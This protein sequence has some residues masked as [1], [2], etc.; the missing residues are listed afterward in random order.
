MQIKQLLENML[1]LGGSDLHVT[2]GAS[3]MV[4]INGKLTFTD[5]DRLSSQD[6]KDMVTSI[7]Q[8]HQKE[9]LE[10]NMELSFSYSMPGLARFRVNII[11]QRGSMA[12]NFRVVATK[13]PSLDDLKLPAAVKDLCRHSRGLVLV[14]GP[15][16]SGKSTTLAGMLGLINK[17]RSLNI[18]TIENP[19]EFLHSHYKS[20]INQREVGSDTR[21]LTDALRSMLLHDPDVI[22]IGEI[23]SAE[24]ASAALNAVETGRLVFSTLHS[25]TTISGIQCIL[26]MYP[27]QLR[28]N[29]RKQLADSL[30]GIVSQQLIPRFDGKGKVVAVELLLCTPEVKNLIKDGKEQQLYNIMQS[31]SDIGMSTFDQALVELC[32][33]KIISSAMAKEWCSNCAELEQ[34]LRTSLDI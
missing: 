7:L 33:Q 4:R 11:H 17:E 6:I 26:S 12:A 18:V 14:T 20:I 25:R 22:L 19:I 27:N 8:P 16:G 30:L 10:E 15:A 5:M 3:P 23:R 1:N 9:M 34:L 31:S 21:S 24:T 2:A 13:V 29:V 32:T 28:E